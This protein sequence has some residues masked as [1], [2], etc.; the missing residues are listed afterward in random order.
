[1]ARRKFRVPAGRM[2]TQEEEQ[3][4]Y[5]RFWA[6]DKIEWHEEG[7]HGVIRNIPE[8]Q[9]VRFKRMIEF[10]MGEK[11]GY[12]VKHPYQKIYDVEFVH[13]TKVYPPP[14]RPWEWCGNSILF[15]DWQQREEANRYAMAAIRIGDQV[16]FMARG[17]KKEGIVTGMRKRVSVL[18]GH[19]RW[20]VSADLLNKTEVSSADEARGRQ[21][22]L[23]LG[24]DLLS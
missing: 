7:R 23:G 3:A 6:S 20:R 15:K 18:V 17:I 9:A 5:D 14:K 4:K 11:A 12:W 10:Y 13:M 1:M 22:E 2:G 21:V 24:P 8:S 16:S 19:E